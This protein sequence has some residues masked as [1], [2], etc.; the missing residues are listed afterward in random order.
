VS[1]H[2]L[3]ANIAHDMSPACHAMNVAAYGMLLAEHLGVSSFA[4]KSQI[5]TGALLHDLGKRSSAKPGDHHTTLGYIELCRN[6]KLSRGGLMMI[7]QHHEWVNGAGE[8]VA[9]LGDEIHP[10]AK[11]L[12]V[13]NQFDSLTADDG[14]R[15]GLDPVDAIGTLAKRANKQ[16]DLEV[17][18]CWISIF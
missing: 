5:A 11:L 15:R 16:F 10:W 6:D 1:A 2:E 7:Y 12:A 14:G 4:E 9:I 3:F 17:L 13:V 18:R 8:P